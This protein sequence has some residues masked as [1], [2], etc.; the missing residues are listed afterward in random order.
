M[1]SPRHSEEQDRENR[2]TFKHNVGDSEDSVT[3]RFGSD[4]D[5]DPLQNCHPMTGGTEDLTLFKKG[6]N[7]SLCSTSHI[8]FDSSIL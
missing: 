1:K 3:D 8:L 4:N 5:V 6:E 2:V 7:P